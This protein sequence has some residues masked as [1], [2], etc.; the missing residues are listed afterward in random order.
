MKQDIGVYTTFV[1]STFPVPHVS[2]IA[3]SL[4]VADLHLSS[5]SLKGVAEKIQA[6][7]VHKNGRASGTHKYQN[8]K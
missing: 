4:Q 8:L 1:S 2:A 6:S 5:P 7:E 3:K